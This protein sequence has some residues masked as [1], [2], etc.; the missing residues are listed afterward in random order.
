MRLS[1]VLAMGALLVPASAAR[2]DVFFEASVFAHLASGAPTVDYRSGLAIGDLDHDGI[3]DVV[4]PSQIGA[5]VLRGRG[6]GT[7]ELP[8]R[9][10]GHAPYSAIGDFDGDGH[11]DVAWMTG[12]SF[13]DGT[14]AGWDSLL[15]ASGGR[16][17]AVADFD[18][19][20]QD[21]FVAHVYPNMLTTW[22][23]RPGRTFEAVAGSD[24]LP[25][26][27]GVRFVRVCDLNQ[28]GH[29]D[30]V[31]D[32]ENAS[33]VDFAALLGRG[34]GTFALA[35][36]TLP[37][38]NNQGLAVA[39]FT[40]DGIPDVVISYGWFLRLF[41]GHGDGTFAAPEIIAF[42][43]QGEYDLAAGDVTG[44]GVPDL[45]TSMFYQQGLAVRAGRGDGTFDPYVVWRLDMS[46][47][48]LQLADMNGDGHLDAVSMCESMPGVVVSPGDGQGRFGAATR[49][50][51]T[52]RNAADVGIADLDG[53]G[54]QDVVTIG[55]YATESALTVMKGLGG[56]AFAPAV[57]VPLLDSGS[58]VPYSLV[59]A[60]L[61]RDAIPDAVADFGWQVQTARGD[62]QGGFSSLWRMD[63]GASSAELRVADAN[64]DTIPD[65]IGTGPSSIRVWPGIG[66]GTFGAPLESAVPALVSNVAVGDLNGD[67]IPDLGFSASTGVTSKWVTFALGDGTGHFVL[68][69]GQWPVQQLA[70][71]T[72]AIGDVTGDG[73]DDLVALS[74]A[75]P[76]CGGTLFCGRLGVRAQLPDGSLAP[77]VEQP[78]VQVALDRVADLNGDGRGDLLAR[79]APG[80]HVALADEGGG[81]ALQPGYGVGG[82]Y[83][84][85]SL[86][87]GDLD[88]DG[89]T[90][91]AVC[92]ES[93][94]HVFYGRDPD[95]PTLDVPDRRI[96]APK[97]A[98]ILAAWPNPTRGA[99]QV[100]FTAPAAGAAD[101]ALFDLAGRRRATLHRETG[102]AA[103]EIAVSA[104]TRGLKPGVYFLRL[105]TGAGTDNRRIVLLD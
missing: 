57:V 29:A 53:D 11:A 12:V 18:E 46:L 84:S 60:D 100:R 58:R 77:W 31:L 32:F 64:G 73:R 83:G 95:G 67:G 89:L 85:R 79:M 82:P 42:D 97:G 75:D 49:R 81:F 22:L 51:P 5:L 92:V 90:D 7:L 27:C 54:I 52:P 55:G 35:P 25:D 98:R 62:G 45:V 66:D 10:Y 70:F 41:R 69:S 40:S 6:D 76:W 28:D 15:L 65:L 43:S 19:D 2:A 56:R 21:D 102:A 36:Q 14:A 93:D 59:L 78:W 8:V 1:A 34:D 26:C 9:A 72:V 39:D 61:N 87:L 80:I 4:A 24:S 17:V 3:L 99:L 91:M 47:L 13:G 101:L 50:L 20:G 103:G 33:D 68:S 105:A 96:R 94:V 74:A 88:A 30:L 37:G 38:G 48:G 104:S 23:G 71:P 44:D 86:A 63:F 16:G